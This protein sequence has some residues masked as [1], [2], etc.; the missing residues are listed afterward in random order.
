[1]RRSR[2]IYFDSWRRRNVVRDPFEETHKEVFET[3]R[4]LQAG[5]CAP[6]LVGDL[7]DHVS[8]HFIDEDKFMR[9]VRFPYRERHIEDH[10]AIQELILKLL[11]HLVSGSITEEEVDQ[12]REKLVLH[13][14]TEDANL[15]RYSSLHYP[16]VLETYEAEKHPKRSSQTGVGHRRSFIGRSSGSEG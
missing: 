12:I 11:P 7:I 8:L 13:I 1:M 4:K 5:S 9:E 10:A 6:E 15:L 14:R 16:E 3:L 2:G